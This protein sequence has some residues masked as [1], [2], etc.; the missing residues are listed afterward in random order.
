MGLEPRVRAW[1]CSAFT[2]V[3]SPEQSG[4]ASFPD[5]D[6]GHVGDGR[7]EPRASINK[8]GP[9]NMWL[10]GSHKGPAGSRSPRHAHS[11]V[12]AHC[13]RSI[14]LQW[15]T[16]GAEN[17][18]SPNG[19]FAFPPFV[20]AW[21]GSYG[22]CCQQTPG[23]PLNTPNHPQRLPLKTGRMIVKNSPGINQSLRAFGK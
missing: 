7:N 11:R 4:H 17:Q 1:P 13:V 3:N 15:E 6:A 9:P 14:K 18:L 21:L 8:P 16:L 5:F 23:W 19:A 2:G 10:T 22:F 20:A 12:L